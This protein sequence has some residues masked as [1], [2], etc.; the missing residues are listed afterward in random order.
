[1]SLEGFTDYNKADAQEYDRLRWWAGFTFGDILDKASDMHP[2]KEALVDGDRRLTY[3]QVRELA[4]K[5]AIGF[6]ELGIKPKER[7]LLQ[8]PNWSEFV[9]SFFALQKIGA[10]PV[11]LVP[12]HSQIEIN[13]VCRLTGATAWILPGEHRKIDYLPIIDGVL[14]ENPQLRHVILVRSEDKRFHSL[15][16][17]LKHA[18][19]NKDNLPELAGRRPDPMEVARM[20]T[21]GGS[22][23]VLKIVPRTH[24]DYLCN[25]EYKARTWKLSTDDVSLAVTPVGHDMTFSTIIC[26]A[27]ITFG[28]IIMLDSTNSEDICSTIQKE[29]I[30]AAAM[31]PTLARQ[32]AD[33]DSIRN[34]D[35]SSL[36][37]LHVGG[38]L[39]SPDLIR[40]VHHNL[41]CKYVNAYG[42]S[43]GISFMTRLDDDLDTICDSVGKPTC[44]YDMHKIVDQDGNELPPDTPG[45]LLVKGPGVFSGYFNDLEAN[46]LAFTD[47]G[48]FRTGDLI[49][50]DS[51]GTARIAGRIKDVIIRGGEN[52]LP[53]EVESLISDHH[54]VAAV[55]VIGMPDELLG[56]R[57][58]AYIQLRPGSMLSFEDIIDYL[59]GK[60]ASVRQLPERIEFIDDMPLTKVGK[61]DKQ[62]LRH[63][64][65]MRLRKTQ[66]LG[67]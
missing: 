25:V 60:R 64:I 39:S 15:N 63:D 41:G 44:P 24:N 16:G 30:T 56:E 11:L 59:K 49:T 57:I 65:E 33:F 26:G 54:G 38:S 35:L 50:I 4:D 48:F 1:M 22:T 61:A 27:V 43:E 46:R 58:C 45:E 55:A 6:M 67:T 52:I 32:L 13:H 42:S 23:G 10:I 8:L 18:R 3:S 34:Y 12:R 28:K 5:C 2:E 14:R 21:T 53:A 37:K 66:L 20:S 40:S 29:R 19:I 17:L 62:A 47:D 36:V 9:Y 31:V 7:V 51:D